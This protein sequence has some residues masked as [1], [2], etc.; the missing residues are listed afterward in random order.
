MNLSVPVTASS[1]VMVLSCG[2]GFGAQVSPPATDR[3][4]ADICKDERLCLDE[5]SEQEKLALESGGAVWC[6]SGVDLPDG[7]VRH[8]FISDRLIPDCEHRAHMARFLQ[9]WL[10][11]PTEES[12][13][14]VIPGDLSEADISDAIVSLWGL[15]RLW[16]DGLGHNRWRWLYVLED[17]RRTKLLLRLIERHGLSGDIG[18]VLLKE[19]PPGLVPVLKQVARC[20]ESSCCERILAESLLNNAGVGMPRAIPDCAGLRL[21]TRAQIEAWA[22]LERRLSTGDRVTW[23]I[24]L[25]IGCWE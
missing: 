24:I 12:A 6:V 10:T 16:I 14:A 7:G 9:T 11:H 1:M 18:Y 20:S 21:V 15:E 19:L 5:I 4:T 2:T 3:T 13:R 22:E 25:D 17:A 8:L 23:A